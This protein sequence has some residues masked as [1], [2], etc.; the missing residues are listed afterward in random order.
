MSYLGLLGLA[1]ALVVHFILAALNRLLRHGWLVLDRWWVGLRVIVAALALVLLGLAVAEWR[2]LPEDLKSV[3]QHLGADNPDSS[4][5]P[6]K[7]NGEIKR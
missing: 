1:V 6:Q 3:G 5:P 4:G 2:H 7:P